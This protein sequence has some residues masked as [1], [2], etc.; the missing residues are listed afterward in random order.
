MVQGALM[1]THAVP[2]TS[3]VIKRFRQGETLA[4]RALA[5]RAEYLDGRIELSVPSLLGC[6]VT[7]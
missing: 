7:R 5:L 1:D 2:D 4:E 3:V 6:W